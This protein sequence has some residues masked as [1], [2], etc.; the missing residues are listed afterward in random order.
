[1]S[2]VFHWFFISEQLVSLLMLAINFHY[3]AAG[4]TKHK[5]CMH[6]VVFPWY[7]L[8]VTHRHHC[9]DTCSFHI[10]QRNLLKLAV[11]SLTSLTQQPLEASTSAT[12]S[13]HYSALLLLC[14]TLHCTTPYIH[15]H[16][17]YNCAHTPCYPTHGHN[18]MQ[19]HHINKKMH[20]EL[21]DGRFKHVFH[22]ILQWQHFCINFV[23]VCFYTHDL[24][25]RSFKWSLSYVFVSF[26]FALHLLFM[27]F[28]SHCIHYT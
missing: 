2:V 1:M 19:R 8:T 4:K 18:M 17:A 15:T 14:T 27:P 7:S 20:L 21:C 16:G 6:T 13:W 22:D 3:N 11:T 24:L 5:Y 28:G 12:R 26:I 25:D 23:V 10:Y 9:N